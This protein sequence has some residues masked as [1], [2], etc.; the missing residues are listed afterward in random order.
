M[1]PI[2]PRRLIP[3]LLKGTEVQQNKG[4][5]LCNFPDCACPL[6]FG[7]CKAPFAN[8]GQEMQQNNYDPDT[9]RDPT[10]RELEGG[11]KHLAVLDRRARFLQ[12]RIERGKRDGKNLTHDVHEM[13]A[14][15]WAIYQLESD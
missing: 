4:K 12:S 5:R 6:Q 13:E 14:L 15:E 9:V 1:R 10:G 11:E 7:G 8:Q 3:R 2:N